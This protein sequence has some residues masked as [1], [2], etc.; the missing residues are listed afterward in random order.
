MV[1]V[2]LSILMEV[3]TWANG[4]T[5]KK[6][7]KVNSLGSITVPMREIFEMTS[8]TVKVLSRGQVA[9]LMKD[10]GEIIK[11]MAEAP[12]NMLME[13][14]TQAN[15]NKKFV[16]V[17]ENLLS[18]MVAATME[19]GKTRLNTATESQFGHPV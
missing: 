1:K 8:C 19:N 3:H 7:A 9:P 16:T 6:T 10:S 18:Q 11:R 2:C 15:G 12:L 14:V 5:S 13:A 4:E 17:Q